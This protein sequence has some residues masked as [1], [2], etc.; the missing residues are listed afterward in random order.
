MKNISAIPLLIL[1]FMCLWGL[2]DFNLDLD[3]DLSKFKP[4][5]SLDLES[6]YSVGLP[7][8]SH[9]LQI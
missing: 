3:L 4:R 7:A 9:G 1:C 2:L 6:L 5:S 8:V